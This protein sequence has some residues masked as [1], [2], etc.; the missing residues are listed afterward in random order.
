[1]RRSE[2]F[3]TYLISGEVMGSRLDGAHHLRAAPRYKLF[4]PTN[5]SV[6]GLENRAH[7]LNLSVGGALL[8]SQDA[9]APGTNVRVWCGGDLLSARVVWRE[10]RRFGLAFST[11]LAH[12]KIAEVIAAQDALISGASRPAA[13]S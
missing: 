11:P 4:Q 1:M 6:A 7:L 10:D 13:G 5:V 2:T 8:Y 12:A 3:C 9:P